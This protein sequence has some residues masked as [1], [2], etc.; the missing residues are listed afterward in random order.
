[1]RCV[2]AR[3]ALRIHSLGK[4]RG[5]W[6]DREGPRLALKGPWSQ[7][8]PVTHQP[9]SRGHVAS[10][11]GRGFLRCKANRCRRVSLPSGSLSGLQ[12]TSPTPTLP[13]LLAQDG[14]DCSSGPTAQ[15]PSWCGCRHWPSLDCHGHPAPTSVPQTQ[16][17]HMFF[18]F[19]SR[20]PMDTD[21]SAPTLLSQRKSDP[22]RALISQYVG[23]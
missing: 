23:G 22:G 3:R 21:T 8:C 5:S 16:A 18:F 17:R 9:G 14:V 20:G 6:R 11:A 13:E 7:P 12:G 4:E 10:Q 15:D 19:P 2:R 1:M